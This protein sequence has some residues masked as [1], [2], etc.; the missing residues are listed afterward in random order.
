M[1]T[2]IDKDFFRQFGYWSKFPFF[3]GYFSP[4]FRF[5]YYFRKSQEYSLHHPLGILFRLLLR[6]YSIR[7]GYQISAK[8][9]IGDGLHLGHWGTV[10]I[11]PKSRIGMNC[12]I[13]HGV[14][15]GQ[16]NRGAAKGVPVI[17]NDVW[18]GA[19]AVI[20]GG[21]TI[22]NNVLIAP[23]SYVTKDIPDNSIVVGNPA[24]IIFNERATDGY[25]NN[26]VE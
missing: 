7:Y 26:R 23:N 14:T 15:I 11:N 3:K 22:G 1:K 18:I 13:S 17:Q 20:V 10:V 25:I 19:N 24:Q 8:T 21:I 2:I 9:I 4:G 6:K 16:T 5:T 12:N